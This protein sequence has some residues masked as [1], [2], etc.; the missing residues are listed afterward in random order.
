MQ[1]YINKYKDI[2]LIF[3]IVLV[4]LLLRRPDAF[5]NPQLYAEDGVVFFGDYVK[6]GIHSII[7][8]YAGYLHLVPRFV[9]ALFGIC[10]VNYLYIPACYNYTT[11]LITFW[12]AVEL[13]K[14]A[15]YLDLKN[16]VL[17][18]TWFLLIP[19]G[20][21]IHMNMCNLIF[22]TALYLVNY[23]LIGYRHGNQS[24]KAFIILII[25]LTGPFSILLSPMVLLIVFLERKTMTFKK[26]L[27]YAMILAGGFVQFIYMKFV[28]PNVSRDI[29]GVAE[30][31]HWIRV[32]TNAVSDVFFIRNRFVL[33][34]FVSAGFFALLLLIYRKLVMARKYLLVIVPMVFFSAFIFGYWPHASRIHAFMSPRHYLIP[35]TCIGWLFILTLDK[36]IKLLQTLVYIIYFSFQL[37][38]MRMRD[39]DKHWSKQIGEYYQGKTD[40]IEINPN[41]NWL[42][43]LPHYKN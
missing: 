5:I 42:I 41:P 30:D 23:L 12:I 13:W 18:A 24:V 32:F 34:I 8:P 9:A 37:P 19:T 35:Y 31:L 29:G 7:I 17:Y 3:V 33:A 26:L 10:Q 20:S 21:E 27:P 1:T 2:G 36:S 15:V 40:S 43:R 14:S 4:I 25:S 6:S 39:A 28:M 11:F 16:K 22:L 38:Y